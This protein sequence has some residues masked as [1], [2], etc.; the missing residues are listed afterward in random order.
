MKY[1]DTS[2]HYGEKFPS[3][4]RADAAC[5]HIG[6]FVAWCFLNGFIGDVH[7]KTPEILEELLDRYKTPGVW[8]MENCDGK[9]TDEDLSKV[10]NKFAQSY[11]NTNPSPYLDDYKSTMNKNRPTIYHA[12][13]SWQFYD[14]LAPKIETRFKLWCQE[15]PKDCIDKD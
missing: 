9:F 14:R 4:L 15:N 2:W 3:D 7:K 1:D 8:F 5:I 10:G 12:P 6:M 13:D 11:Y